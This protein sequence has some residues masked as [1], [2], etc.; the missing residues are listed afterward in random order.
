MKT[1]N[2]VFR[3]AY[4]APFVAGLTT[5]EVVSRSDKLVFGSKKQRPGG[6]QRVNAVDTGKIR[7]KHRGT[8]PKD[9]NL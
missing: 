9:H 1:S 2:S 4:G 6:R 3:K 8:R 5:S 7:Y